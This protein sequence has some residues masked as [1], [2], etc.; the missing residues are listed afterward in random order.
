MESQPLFLLGSPRSGTTFFCHVLNRHPL[1]NL[2][3]E[4]RLFVL[5]K[6][7]VEA[8]CFRPDLL[9][10][11]LRVAFQDYV[12]RNAGRWIETFYREELGFRAP[13]WGDK[14]PSY[15]DPAVLS[16][17]WSGVMTEPRSGSCLRLIRACLPNAKFIH[18]HRHPWQVAASMHRRGWVDSIPIGLQVWRQYVGEIEEFLAELDEDRRLTLSFAGLVEEPA[19]VAGEIAS[20]LGLADAGPIAR[21]LAAQDG[22]RTPFSDPTSDLSEPLHLADPGKAGRRALDDV[23]DLAQRF[24]YSPEAAR[25][26]WR[27]A[28]D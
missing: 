25:P 7:L 4:S 14:H 6:D 27:L 8:R 9:D 5:V 28:A 3:S 15:G 23:A 13:V 2:T 26:E 24:G 10:G 20:F 21:F 19:E 16:G 22:G 12:L 17:R 11:S 18:L 1:I